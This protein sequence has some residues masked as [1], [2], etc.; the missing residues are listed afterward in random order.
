MLNTLRSVVFYPIFVILFFLES[1]D[2]PKLPT[3]LKPTTGYKKEKPTTVKPTEYRKQK[4]T[5]QKPD[6]QDIPCSEDKHRNC[7]AMADKGYCRIFDDIMSEF[8]CKTCQGMLIK[9][10]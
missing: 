7:K 9:F 8:C 6:D 3:T 10:I 1:A 5:T 4:P 2:D